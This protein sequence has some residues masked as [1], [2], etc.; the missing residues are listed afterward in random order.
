MILDEK[1]LN[2]SLQKKKKLSR[3]TLIPENSQHK[4]GFSTETNK[5]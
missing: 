5:G 1:K 2:Q 3:Y 4:R